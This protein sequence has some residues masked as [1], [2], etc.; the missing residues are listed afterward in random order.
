MAKVHSI[1]EFV[2]GPRIAP[3]D[4]FVERTETCWWWRGPVVPPHGY[5]IYRG[6]GNSRLRAHRYAYM[7]AFGPINDPTLFV[8]H[9]CDN[10]LCVNPEHLFLGTPADNVLDMFA[11]GRQPS[12][13]RRKTAKLT[14]ADVDEIRRLLN[15]GELTQAAIADR[16]GVVYSTVWFIASGKTWRPYVPLRWVGHRARRR[17]SAKPLAPQGQD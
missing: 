4:T 8:C 15:A 14:Q 1:E 6:K 12:P 11:K 3:F 5:G 9:R 16:F 7:Q 2:P 13:E 17:R 10:K